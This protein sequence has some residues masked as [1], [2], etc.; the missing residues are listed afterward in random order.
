VPLYK[1]L[2]KNGNYALASNIFEKAKLNYHPA[3]TRAVS[4][5]FI[6]KEIK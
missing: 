3:T 2:I 1:Q 5:L 6:K 4:E